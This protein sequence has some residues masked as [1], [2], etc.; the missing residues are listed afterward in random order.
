MLWMNFIVKSISWKRVMFIKS[1]EVRG[2]TRI[3]QNSI[4]S[5]EADFS[6]PMQIILGGNGSGKSS[7]M[8]Q[9]AGLPPASS[10][11]EKDGALHVILDHDGS[12]FELISDQEDGHFFSR[13]GEVLNNWGTAQVQKSL[14]ETHLGINHTIWSILIGTTKFTEMSPL[15]RRDWVMYLSK[16]NIE[17][18]M[19]V[20]QEAKQ[21]QRDLKGHVSKVAERL[22][23]EVRNTVS[24]E[25]IETLKKSIAELKDEFNYYSKFGDEANPPVTNQS[26]LEI[27]SSELIDFMESVMTNYPKVPSWVLQMGVKNPEDISNTLLVFKTRL[28]GVTANYD[29]AMVELGEINILTEAAASLEK[30]G[31][32]TAEQRFRQLEK[33]RNDLCGELGKWSYQINTDPSVASHDYHRIVGE[34]RKSIFELPDNDDYKYN[35]QAY[36]DATARDAGMHHKLT[37]IK[38]SIYKREHIIEHINKAEVINCPSCTYS[39]KYGVNEG[40]KSKAE[41]ELVNLKESRDSLIKQIAENKE[42]MDE[43]SDFIGRIKDIYST[44]KLTPSNEP[45]WVE[46]RKLEIFKSNKYQAFELLDNHIEYLEKLIELKDVTELFNKERDVWIKAR[47]SLE[48]VNNKGTVETTKIDEKIYQYSADIEKLT[49]EIQQL[50]ELKARFNK[51]EQDLQN[52][53]SKFEDFNALLINELDQDR[54]NFIKDVKFRI[55]KEVNSYEQELEQAKTKNMIYADISEQHDKALLNYEEVSIIVDNLSPNTGL[56]ADFMN[57]SIK[58]F[59]NN[60]NTV[61]K[62]IWT[63]P[64]EVMPCVNKRNDLDWKFPVRVDND[65]VRPDISK[66]S[67][68][69]GD[70]INL[71]F[72]LTLIKHLGLGEYPVCLDEVGGSMDEQ[73]RLNT[74][75]II[76]ELTDTKYCSQVFFISHHTAFHSNFKDA[77]TL[78]INTDN[79]INIPKVYNQHVRIC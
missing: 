76:E 24:E 27:R 36:N 77:E 47:E 73:H 67:T 19:T 56:I 30:V 40:D 54:A 10:D 13:D 75:R 68:S 16:L 20:F 72:Q 11:Y 9:I 44:M 8:E 79:L 34:L 78:I 17:P 52:I 7:L 65:M 5:L 69:Q 37:E 45:L 29:K 61:I 1:I 23:I 6:K 26:D 63:S 48:I 28:E 38:E 31:V 41:N 51:L 66:T 57:D 3:K 55:M 70:V 12:E 22:K 64:L 14:I 18:L 2:Y 15:V 21:Q 32:A 25:N 50:E 39:F 49:K 53:E 35:S 58:T 59:V 71:A 62:S 43:C 46:I 42:F 74:M 33:Q 4:S 60:L